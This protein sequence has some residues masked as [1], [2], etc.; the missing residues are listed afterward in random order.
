MFNDLQK[1]K[2]EFFAILYIVA[3]FSPFLLKSFSQEWAAFGGTLIWL[4]ASIAYFFAYLQVVSKLP[5]A[6]RYFVTWSI[7]T[8]F[9]Q[10]LFKAALFFAIVMLWLLSSVVYEAIFG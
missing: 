5:G 9:P 10:R 6:D 4:L 1:R 3:L 2:V 8:Y 7:S